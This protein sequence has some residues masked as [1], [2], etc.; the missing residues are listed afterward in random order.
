MGRHLLNI[1]LFGPTNYTSQLI[2]TIWYNTSVYL[3][4]SSIPIQKWELHHWWK[5]QKHFLSEYLNFERFYW[6]S[7][8]EILVLT[9]QLII[10]CTNIRDLSSIEHL[11]DE[12]FPDSLLRSYLLWLSIFWGQCPYFNQHL[13]G[14]ML[15][16][17]IILMHAMIIEVTSSKLTFWC[18][19]RNIPSGPFY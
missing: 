15:R 2:W 14:G 16:V 6:I 9:S 4:N 7:F 10:L 19:D 5:L 18:W 3:F 17:N 11:K 12:D 13:P 8:N 1:T